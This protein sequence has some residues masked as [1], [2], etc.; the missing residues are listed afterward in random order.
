MTST[1]TPG[2]QH[3]RAVRCDVV[4][5]GDERG[6]VTLATGAAA[7]ASSAEAPLRRGLALIL[8]LVLETDH[9]PRPLA[10]RLSGQLRVDQALS[11]FR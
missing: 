1:T 7:A 11:S 8:S 3:A 4:V 2:V 9:A 5:R 6:L 10:G